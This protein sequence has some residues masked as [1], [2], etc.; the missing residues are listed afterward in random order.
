MATGK[1]KEGTVAVITWGYKEE[2]D[3]NFIQYF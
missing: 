2:A 1:N 3:F